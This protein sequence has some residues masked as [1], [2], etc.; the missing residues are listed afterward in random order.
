MADDPNR[1]PVSGK[2]AQTARSGRATTSPPIENTAVLPS[3]GPSSD[4]CYTS[5]LHNPDHDPGPSVSKRSGNIRG[6]GTL[7]RGN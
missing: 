5:L 3:G 2:A 7:N 6:S 1:K 4:D